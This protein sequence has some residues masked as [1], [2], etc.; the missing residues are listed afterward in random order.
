M[1]RNIKVLGAALAA[2][3][4][5][6]LAPTAAWSKAPT[7]DISMT[8]TQYVEGVHTSA[9]VFYG[10]QIVYDLAIANTSSSATSS[11]TIDFPLTRDATYVTGTDSC[12]AVPSCTFDYVTGNVINLDFDVTS[13]PVGGSG[14]LSVTLTPSVGSQFQPITEVA[15]LI[16]DGCTA[17]VC[18]SNKVANQVFPRPVLLTG[19]PNDGVAIPPGGTIVY[20][21]LAKNPQHLKSQTDV[22][23][24]DTVPTGTSY[25]AGSASCLQ[26]PGCTASE[27]NNVVTYTIQVIPPRPGDLYRVTF[28]VTAN[29]TSGTIVDTANWMGDLCTVGTCTTAQTLV[30]VSPTAP[31]GVTVTKSASPSTVSPGGKLTYSL[32]VAN[33]TGTTET[34]LVI[35]DSAPAGTTYDS[36]S[37]K[38]HDLPGCSATQS[39][40]VVKFSIP[41]LAVGASGDVFFT[42]T[43]A[44]SATGSISNVAQWTGGGCASGTTCSSNQVITP[45]GPVTTSYTS[46]SATTTTSAPAKT[47]AATSPLAYT[48]AGPGL[49]ALFLIAL[50]LIFSGV[51]GLAAFA[52]FRLN[53]LWDILVFGR[54]K[55]R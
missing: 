47:K 48:G 20:Y 26:A 52:V 42:V 8:L 50:G 55:R 23:I 21:I 2:M 3:G 1:R 17:S 44:K 38:C 35:T 33:P 25:V 16:G 32:A 5:V 22:T 39:G 11:F 45:V 46:P 43:V 19:Y 54:R 12:G 18:A 6:L 10:T 49:R 31:T 34:N 29:I 40:G 28:S 53:A 9:P 37:A 15:H 41:S 4:V 24:T 27:S 14:T 36:G 51:L 7:S 30:I 13:L